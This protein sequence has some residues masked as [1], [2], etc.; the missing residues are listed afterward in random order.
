MVIGW[1]RRA[2]LGNADATDVL[3]EVFSSVWR[4]IG[5]YCSERG[6]FRGWL[7][8]ITVRKVQDVARRHNRS[9]AAP[10]GSANHQG[11]QNIIAHGVPDTDEDIE[12]DERQLVR[13]TAE[14]VRCEF[15]ETTWQAFWMTAVETRSAIDV[16]H[17]LGISRAAVYQAK[18]RVLKRLRQELEGLF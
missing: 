9:V 6:S 1:C 17:D 5:R 2:N 14:L 15:E 18:S 11:I 4:S 8:T 10:G 3:Q 12:T 16:G 13:R 7:K